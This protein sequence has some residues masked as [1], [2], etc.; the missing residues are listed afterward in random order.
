MADPQDESRLRPHPEQRFAT[1]HL[2]LDLNMVADRLRAERS[3]GERGHRQQTLYRHNGITIALFVFEKGAKLPS[4]KAD[5]TVNIHVLHG[6]I[7]LTVEEQAYTLTAG[8]VLILAS[9]VRHAVVAEEPSEML[10]TVKLDG[11]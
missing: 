5:G 3:A 10:L 9:G 6:R 11:N 1:T 4:H 2:Q 7:N 8:Q